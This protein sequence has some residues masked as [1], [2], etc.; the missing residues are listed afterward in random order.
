MRGDHLA[1]TAQHARRF[2]EADAT[3]AVTAAT[4]GA[5]QAAAEAEAAAAAQASE[6]PLMPATSAPTTQLKKKIVVQGRS[7]QSG[8]QDKAVQR[9]SPGHQRNVAIEA[10]G[11]EVSVAAGRLDMRSIQGL[12]SFRHPPDITIQVVAAVATILGLP[13]LGWA[14]MRK[15]LNSGLLCSIISF[16][17]KAAEECPKALVDKFLL[18]ISSPPLTDCDNLEGKCSAVALLAAWCFAVGRLLRRIHRIPIT[19]ALNKY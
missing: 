10:A 17:A 8:K 18:V 1:N 4:T 7:S 16:D 15:E 6:T 12:R 11:L 14:A 2:P 3:Q 9:L 13:E 5:V 19:K